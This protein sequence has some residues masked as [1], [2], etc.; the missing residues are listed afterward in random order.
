MQATNSYS[1]EV[2]EWWTI[3]NIDG[4]PQRVYC[5]ARIRIQGVKE[6]VAIM[7]QWC[8]MGVAYILMSNT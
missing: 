5:M 6:F 7:L 3:A 8:A 4:Y 2:H 1:N